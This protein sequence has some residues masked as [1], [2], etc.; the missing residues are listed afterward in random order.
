MERF[1]WEKHPWKDV[2]YKYKYGLWT[3]F[4]KPIRTGLGIGERAIIGAG[5]LVNK[6]ISEGARTVGVPCWLLE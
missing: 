5:T 6:S 1:C 4:T 2:P 3:I